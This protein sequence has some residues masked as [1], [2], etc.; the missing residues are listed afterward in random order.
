M[1][2]ASLPAQPRAGGAEYTNPAVQVNADGPRRDSEEVALLRAQ[3]ALATEY[4]QDLL[5]T[6]YFALATAAGV[7]VI[8]VGYSW[9]TN[10]QIRERELAAL[11]AEVRS[12]LDRGAADIRAELTAQIQVGFTG[13]EA[14]LRADVKT[15]L[16]ANAKAQETAHEAHTKW[17]QAL[18]QDIQNMRISVDFE[19][20]MAKAN[21]WELSRVPGNELGDYTEALPLAVCLKDEGSITTC[22]TAIIRLGQSGTL[23]FHGYVPGLVEVLNSLPPRYATEVST[24]K[25]LLKQVSRT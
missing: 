8:L 7:T 15:N 2:G 5:Q 1:M 19:R 3:L 11:K 20:L 23:P 6:V 24:I 12:S 17:L 25:G 22:L 10:F 9:F 4:K 21:Y 18:R 14:E 13:A 16:E